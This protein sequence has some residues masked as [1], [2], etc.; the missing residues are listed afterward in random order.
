MPP[1][2]PRF[3]P[4][5]SLIETFPVCMGTAVVMMVVLLYWTFFVSVCTMPVPGRRPPPT[6]F[7]NKQQHLW[8]IK[9]SPSGSVLRRNIAHGLLLL[10]L[11]VR[12]RNVK[13]AILSWYCLHVCCLLFR[14]FC[15]LAYM[16]FG[17]YV[18][19][20]RG[21]A[22]CVCCFL[23]HVF[24]A[25]V[26]ILRYDSVTWTHQPGN[27]QGKVARHGSFFSCSVA[28]K[29]TAVASTVVSSLA[30]ILSVGVG[31]VGL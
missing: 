11:Y 7:F 18:L 20:C 5:S 19:F 3:L 14:L 23:F 16:L 27:T 4:R 25:S 24:C 10:L 28:E 6:K 29:A 30:C 22:V 12:T 13:Q 2:P 17:M 31:C 21:A 15:T 9:R 26:L 8:L 1:P